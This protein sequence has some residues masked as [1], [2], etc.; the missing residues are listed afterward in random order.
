MNNLSTVARDAA[1]D[2][3]VDQIDTG[4]GSSHI[5]IYTAAFGTLLAELDYTTPNAFGNSSSGTATA[6]SITGEAAAPAAGTAAVCRIVDRAGATVWEGTV[7]VTSG[8]GDIE[9]TNLTIAINDTVD[10]TSQTVTMP[11]S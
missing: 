7:T 4:G 9:L 3:V 6:A 5:R 1:C 11:A 8:G 10:I 2:G